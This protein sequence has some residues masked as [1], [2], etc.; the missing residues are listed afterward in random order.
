MPHGTCKLQHKTQVSGGRGGVLRG[1]LSGFGPLPSE[2]NPSQARTLT[3]P[4]V[5]RTWFPSSHSKP[6]TWGFLPPGGA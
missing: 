6:V 2:A 4:S 5:G 1:Q 3:A